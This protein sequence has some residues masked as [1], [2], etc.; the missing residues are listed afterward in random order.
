MLGHKFFI[1]IIGILFSF[2]FGISADLVERYKKGEIKIIPDKTYA[3]SIDW[4][5]LLYDRGVYRIAFGPDDSLFLSS[6]SQ[7]KIFKFDKYGNLILNFGK[8][9]QGPGDFVGPGH[10][11]TLDDKMLVVREYALNRRISLFDFN[12]EFKKLIKT[13]HPPF[14]TIGL[15][16]GIIAYRAKRRIKK[17]LDRHMIIFIDSSDN[18]E[19]IVDSFQLGAKS[20]IPEFEKQYFL[21]K[22]I[23]SN[24]LIGKSNEPEVIIYSPNGEKVFSFKLNMERKKFT[25][26]LKEEFYK[27]MENPEHLTEEMK[28]I[29]LRTYKRSNF[30]FPEYLPYYEDI[31]VDS[32]GNIL[33][34]Y[35]K[36]GSNTKIFKFQVYSPQGDY[37][38]DSSFNLLDHKTEFGDLSDFY[39][40]KSFLYGLIEM[41]DAE[42]Y[43]LRLIRLKLE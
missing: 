28:K 35:H 15:R 10:I 7:N 43:G 24:L 13:A 17:N 25:R 1:L 29:Y 31:K 38:C 42:Y 27:R 23:D 14:Q 39:F 16:N 26:E 8:K 30:K 37:L 19:E 41:K 18:R 34:F 22:T 2:N 5:S 9:G 4:E 36:A 21:A 6:P 3:K 32:D 11:S 40:H 33:V 20:L 12:G